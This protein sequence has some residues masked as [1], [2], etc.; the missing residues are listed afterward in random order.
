[1]NVKVQ[2]CE[3]NQSFV[4]Q[5]TSNDCDFKVDFAIV[6]MLIPVVF[7]EEAS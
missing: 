7:E 5:L 1:M 6:D 4:A 2:M 3:S